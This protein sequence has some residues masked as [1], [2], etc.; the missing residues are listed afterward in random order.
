MLASLRVPSSPGAGHRGTIRITWAHSTPS[1]VTGPGS[2][3]TLSVPG[4][5]EEEQEEM[6][7]ASPL[8]SMSSALYFPPLVVS[9]ETIM[10]GSGTCCAGFPEA[11]PPL[12]FLH[13]TTCPT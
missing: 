9:V 8:S 13:N 3:H 11:A 1:Q 10:M 2:P 12:L 4:I 7:A 6:S 5:K